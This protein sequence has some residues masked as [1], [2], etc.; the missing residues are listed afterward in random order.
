MGGFGRV[1]AGKQGNVIAG[2][3]ATL[4]GGF[5]SGKI[6]YASPLTKVGVGFVANNE[7]LLTMGGMELGAVVGTMV[8]SVLGGGTGSNGYV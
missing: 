6:P 1:F 2:A 7:T 3:L 8:P 4:A 5:L